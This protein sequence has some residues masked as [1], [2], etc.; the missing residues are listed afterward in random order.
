MRKISIFKNGRNQAIRLPKDME[1]EGVTEL[2]IS[3][4]GNTLVLRPARPDWLSMADE[5]TVDPDFL[6]E[7]E[8]VVGDGSLSGQAQ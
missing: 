8:D 2:E 5:Q 1:F 4:K 7:R 6:I 3:R